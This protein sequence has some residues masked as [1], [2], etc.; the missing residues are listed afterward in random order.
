[1]EQSNNSKKPEQV[2]SKYLDMNPEKQ[3]H[4]GVE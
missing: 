3:A 2:P 1:M 4:S